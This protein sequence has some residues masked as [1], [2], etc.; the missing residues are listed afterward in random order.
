M[1]V[2][3]EVQYK[4]AS[5]SSADTG[6]AV[7]SYQRDALLGTLEKLEHAAVHA[8]SDTDRHCYTVATILCAHA[9]G[10]ALLNEWA[11]TQA[12]ALYEEIDGRN[13]SL[14]GAAE[15]VLPHVGAGLSEGLI[16][17]VNMKN[18]LCYPQPVPTPI[19]HSFRDSACRAAAAVR[20]LHT[21]CFPGEQEFD[22][23][24]T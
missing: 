2:A 15:K 17:L 22:N 21:A 16:E 20:A 18:A 6:T 13:F 4:S 11:K 23:T 19:G 12:P 14:L 1:V 9:A 10:E 5:A 7:C 8:T 24:G 3:G